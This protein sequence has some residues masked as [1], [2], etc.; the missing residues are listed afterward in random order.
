MRYFFGVGIDKYKHA[1]FGGQNIDLKQC[2]NDVRRAGAHFSA[3]SNMVQ[4]LYDENATK[5]EILACLRY[6]AEK[7]HTGDVLIYYQSSHGT[8]W[9][10]NTGEITNARLAHDGVIADHEIAAIWATVA[11]GATVLTFSDLCFAG[12]SQR[13]SMDASVKP[14][15]IEWRGTVPMRPTALKIAYKAEFW[16]VSACRF[17]QVSYENALGGVFS[18]LLLSVLEQTKGERSVNTVLKTVQRNIKNQSPVLEKIN[19]KRTAPKV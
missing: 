13:H 12:S 16:H 2:V 11:K 4:Y 19:P 10:E 18:T 14:R 3:S 9:H 7:L 1:A 8:S 5:A 15:S 6:Y 17:D